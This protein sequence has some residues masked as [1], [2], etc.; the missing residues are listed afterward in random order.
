MPKCIAPGCRNTSENTVG[1]SFFRLPL[2]NEALL[3][4]WCDNLG[5]VSPL[6]PGRRVC[7]THFAPDCI[8]SNL[9]ARYMGT[10]SKRRLIVGSVPT[11]P[12]PESNQRRVVEP[13]PKPK[14]RPAM[15]GRRAQNCCIESK[16]GAGKLGDFKGGAQ[17]TRWVPPRF[18]LGSLDSESRVLTIT[19]WNHIVKT[20]YGLVVVCYTTSVHTVLYFSIG[21]FQTESTGRRGTSCLICKL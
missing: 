11:I 6:H 1:V 17:Y 16:A 8:Q 18:E 9:W 2:Q 13:Q 20:V 7:S 4:Q 15:T 14:V 5:I 10:K 21:H 19:P 3:R 12:F